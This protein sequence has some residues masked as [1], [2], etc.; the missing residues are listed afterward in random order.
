[1]NYLS[2]WKESQMKSKNKK[3]VA[4]NNGHKENLSIPILSHLT[5]FMPKKVKK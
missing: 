5:S 1:M 3:S 4:T 2:L